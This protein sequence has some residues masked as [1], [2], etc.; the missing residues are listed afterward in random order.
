MAALAFFFLVILLLAAYPIWRFF[1]KLPPLPERIKRGEAEKERIHK[2]IA[3]GRVDPVK[4]NA[5]IQEIDEKLGE[6]HKQ[7]ATVRAKVL[8]P[9]RPLLERLV[10]PLR[11][12]IVYLFADGYGIKCAIDKVKINS[13][14]RFQRTEGALPDWGRRRLQFGIV[15]FM[16]A[17][18]LLFAAFY[19]LMP[20]TANGIAAFFPAAIFGSLIAWLSPMPARVWYIRRTEDPDKT[21]ELQSVL[22]QITRAEAVLSREFDV[23]DKNGNKIGTEVRHAPPT[24]FTK[25][26]ERMDDEREDLSSPREPTNKIELAM[27]ALLVGGL[28]MGL[29]LF[30]IGTHE[31]NPPAVADTTSE[32]DSNSQPSLS[33][34]PAP[35]AP[36][37]VPQARALLSYSD[38]Q[39]KATGFS[40]DELTV[41]RSV[42]FANAPIPEKYQVKP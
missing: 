28:F 33:Q 2:A 10:P 39:L 22:K 21:G 32:V 35:G 29:F 34:L 20:P 36:F 4:A 31:K 41:L 24:A 17:Y 14:K 1:F 38:A 27:M 8:S 23:L 15:G 18:A 26:A 42:V 37:T 6:L 12:D 19:P 30:V 25:Q 13:D 9:K 11:N 16:P 5:R 40:D 7:L 3:T